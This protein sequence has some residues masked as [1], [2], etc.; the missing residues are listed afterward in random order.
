MHERSKQIYPQKHFIL[1]QPHFLNMI[2]ECLNLFPFSK[3][4][5]T[6]KVRFLNFFSYLR[7][8][9]K[10]YNKITSSTSSSAMSFDT[11]LFESF[12]VETHLNVLCDLVPLIQFKKREKHPWRT[13]IFSK[14]SGFSRR[15]VW[16]CLTILWDGR[17]KG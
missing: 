6:Q 9:W 10:P 3:I 1:F 12:E 13:V 17:F 14:V 2:V 5:P 16:V 7:P 4:S 11:V 15:I 8:W